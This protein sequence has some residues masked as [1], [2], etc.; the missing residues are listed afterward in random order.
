MTTLTNLLDLDPA[1]LIAY[2]GELGEKPFRAKQL[3]RWIHQFGASDFDAMTDLA[4]SLRDKLATRA[5]IAAPA[6][7]SDHTSSDGTRKWL[8]DVG[9]GNA[10]ET[11]FIPEENRGTLCIST[12]A[13][14]AVNC[15]FCSTGKQGFNRNLSVGEIIGQLWMAE[16]ELRRTKGI[17]PG[18]KGERQITNVVM[19]G[20]GEPLLNYEPTVTA[21]K[22]MLDDNAYGLSRRRVTLSTSGVVPM[23]DKLSQDCAVALAVSLHASNDPLRDGLVPL[24][25]KYPLVELMAACKRYLEFAPRD[26]VTFEYCMLDGVNDTD[27]HARELVALVRQAD[28]SCKFNLIPFNPFPESGLTRSQNPRIKAFAQV[29]MDADIITTI[30]KTRGDDIDAACGQLAGEVQDRTKV[31]DRMKKMAEYQEKFGKNFGRIVEIS[32]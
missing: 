32:S 13:G 5:I 31:Q 17:E 27:Q 3:Q 15:R 23:I 22:L 16:F 28:V 26:F 11:V 6:V 2:C 25:K 10:V 4:K 29:L 7:I 12:Q 1:Q 30:R 8:V 21:L 20:M 18:P 24:N 9:Q 14:C 19:M